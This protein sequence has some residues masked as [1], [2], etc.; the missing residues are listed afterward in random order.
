VYISEAIKPSKVVFGLN[1][2][3]YNDGR[4]KITDD[5]YFTCFESLDVYYCISLVVSNTTV[6]ALFTTSF[7]GESFSL[8]PPQNKWR[9]TTNG[10]SGVAY[11]IGVLLNEVMK[12]HNIEHF[13]FMG[14]SSQLTRIY[15]SFAKNKHIVGSLKMFGFDVVD[16]TKKGVVFSIENAKSKVELNRSKKFKVSEL[17]K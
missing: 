1:A 15:H 16:V 17:L 7:D 6:E 13:A 5:V 8:I 4:F 14:Q 10:L 9:R 12:R 11:V 2:P 3:R